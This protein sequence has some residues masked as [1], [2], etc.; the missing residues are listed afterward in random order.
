MGD[1]VIKTGDLIKIT[2]PP[3][4]IVPQLQAPVPLTG[5]ST[6]VMVA[7]MYVCLLG[8]ELPDMISGLLP[9]TAPPFITPGTGRL[10]INLLP[11]N[12]TRQTVNGGKVLLVKGQQ[13]PVTFTVQT[14]AQQPTPT[15]PLPD[16]LPVKQG[17]GQF[18][19]TNMTVFAG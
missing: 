2:I 7:N 8:D 12:M 9:Y 11:A 15:G 5:S 1:L 13:F 19:T 10:Q 4:A 14:P 3:P 18:I 6:N 17:T 16:T